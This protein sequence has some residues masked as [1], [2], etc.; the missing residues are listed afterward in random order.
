MSAW[1]L[2]AYFWA[3]YHGGPLAAEFASKEACEAAITA[4]RQKP[5][6]RWFGEGVCVPKGGVQ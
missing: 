2:I 6:E 5:M 1:I 4:L 3:G